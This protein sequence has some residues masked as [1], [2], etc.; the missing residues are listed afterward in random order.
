MHLI[1]VIQRI[2]YDSAEVSTGFYLLLLLHFNVI[3]V[4]K[5]ILNNIY[6]EYTEFRELV[7]GRSFFVSI[8]FRAKRVN[9]VVPYRRGWRRVP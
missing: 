2:T 6:G 1:A 3:A 8:I 4:N 5:N 9:Y 7:W